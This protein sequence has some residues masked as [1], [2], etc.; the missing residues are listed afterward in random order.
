MSESQP[1]RLSVGA[2]SANAEVRAIGSGLVLAV[3]LDNA[4]NLESEGR[5]IKDWYTVPAEYGG[6]SL[7][8]WRRLYIEWLWRRYGRAG[9]G[10][11]LMRVSKRMARAFGKV[12]TAIERLGVSAESAAQGWKDANVQMREVL[13]KMKADERRQEQV[14]QA[15][16]DRR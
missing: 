12:A 15:G 8:L 13:G 5:P 4:A 16:L 7:T 1:R 10:R 9:L 14:E 3:R 6:R 2:V 11:Y